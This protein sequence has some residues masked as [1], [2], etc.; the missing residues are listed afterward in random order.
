MNYS[1]AP[2]SII[3][4]RKTLKRRQADFGSGTSTPIYAAWL[5][6]AIDLGDLDDVMPKS[7]TVLD[8]QEARA[9]YSRS[10][11][12]GPPAGWVDPEKEATAAKIRMSNGSSYADEC[13]EQGKDWRRVIPKLAAEQRRFAQYGLPSP[14]NIG[15]APGAPR[16]E[17]S[18]E[19]G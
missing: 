16:K 2:G 1:N 15:Q 6:E 11:W 3:E 8:F 7:G 13:A 4:V 12:I 17:P 19:A 18:Q 10:S 9:A 14:H 5:E